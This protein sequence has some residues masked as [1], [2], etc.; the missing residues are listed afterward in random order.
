M[1]LKAI[2]SSTLILFSVI[3]IV[4]IIPVILDMKRQGVKIHPSTATIIAGFVM[5]TF[6]FCGTTLLGLFGIEVRAFALAGALIIFIIGLEMTLGIRF[7]RD[8]T[9]EGSNGSI[10]PTAFPLIAGA[11]TLTTIITLRSQFDSVPIFIAILINLVVVF[12]VLRAS[13]WMSTKI[14][15]NAANTMR[16][17]F[18]ILLLAIAFQ[19]FISQLPNIIP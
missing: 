7:F 5:C 11:G 13:G 4:G 17:V 6:L 2:L 12:V 9:V 18:G 19:M 3:D 16:K 10:V 8:L 15:D 14:N 1:I